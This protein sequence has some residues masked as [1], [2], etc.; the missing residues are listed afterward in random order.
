[1]IGAARQRVALEAVPRSFAALMELYEINYI[2]MR[3]LAPELA[4]AAADRAVSVSRDGV[5]LRLEVIE[6]S[7]YTT[8]VLLTHR[9]EAEHGVESVP[10]LTVRVYHDARTAEAL[11]AQDR[12]VRNSA[13]GLAER[14]AA[15]RFLNRWLRFTLGEGHVFPA[16]G[17]THPEAP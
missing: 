5:A 1:M 7:R 2:Y 4:S 15:N 12:Q 10:D 14:W 16:I 9:F 17:E 8:T 3:R 6:R 13:A 11:Y